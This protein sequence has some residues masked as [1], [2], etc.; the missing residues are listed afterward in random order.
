MGSADKY[1]LNWKEFEENTKSYFRQLR[2]NEEH[3]DLSL[4]CEDGQQ[5]VAQA[6]PLGLQSFLPDDV[7][8]KPSHAP[9]DLHAWHQELKPGFHS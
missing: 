6:R 4:A 8:K 9:T 1:R 7:E 2:V 3:S 5:F